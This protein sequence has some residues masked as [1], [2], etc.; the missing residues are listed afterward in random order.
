MYRG[1]V[2]QLQEVVNTDVAHFGDI[3]SSSQIFLGCHSLPDQTQYFAAM[4]STDQHQYEHL[5]EA[6]ELHQNSSQRSRR[7]YLQT[8]FLQK[9]WQSWRNVKDTSAD[10]PNPTHGRISCKG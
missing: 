7:S 5:V 1:K 8:L 4:Q 10:L 6:K 3:H 2:G 9:L